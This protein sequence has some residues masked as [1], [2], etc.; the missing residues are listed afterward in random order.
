[1]ADVIPEAPVVAS[2]TGLSTTSAESAVVPSLVQPE[3]AM[4]TPVQSALAGSNLLSAAAPVSTPSVVAPPE[5]TNVVQPAPEIEAVESASAPVLKPAIKPPPVERNATIN[6]R[7]NSKKGRIVLKAVQ[8]SWIEVKDAKGG[9][10]FKKL[11][12]EGEEYAP[13]E[14]T[15]YTLV[16]TN[17]GGLGV[18]VDG[19]QVQSLGRQGEILRGIE[20]DPDELKTVK[21][22][23]LHRRSGGRR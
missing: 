7:S 2:V 10:V 23:A 3:A 20:L 12:R 21:I 13:P 9:T 22:R 14:G 19:E 1:M 4:P 16:T 5:K 18:Y 11:L 6:V 8:S 17:A 15:G